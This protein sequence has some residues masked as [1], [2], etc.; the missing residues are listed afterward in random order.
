MSWCFDILLASQMCIS[1]VNV[2]PVWESLSRC[3]LVLL[4]NLFSLSSPLVLPLFLFSCPM[5]ISHRCSV[6]LLKLCVWTG[7]FI[8]SVRINKAVRWMMWTDVLGSAVIINHNEIEKE[9]FRESEWAA[10]FHFPQ[11]LLTLALV[12]YCDFALPSRCR[13]FRLMMSIGMLKW[14]LGKTFQ[15]HSV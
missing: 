13:L 10:Y 14:F 12:I 5:E 11:V 15:Q 1:S 8:S 3:V 9:R 7:F 4:W 2:S 6:C